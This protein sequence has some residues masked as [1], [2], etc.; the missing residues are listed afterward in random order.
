MKKIFLLILIVLAASSLFAEKRYVQSKFGYDEKDIKPVSISIYDEESNLVYAYDTRDVWYFFKQI[1]DKDTNTINTYEYENGKLIREETFS[2]NKY[3]KHL[4]KYNED[5][6]VAYESYYNLYKS[7]AYE[8]FYEVWY[9]YDDKGNEIRKKYSDGT[10]VEKEYNPDG[11]LL[12]M[13]ET[14]S[15]G[16]IEEAEEYNENGLLVKRIG[17][18]SETTCSYE[19]VGAF[20]YQFE[21]HR[22]N[23]GREYN[24]SYVYENGLL[25]EYADSRGNVTEYFYNQEGQ[26]VKEIDSDGEERIWKY[27]SEGR[28]IME[29]YY[30]SYYKFYDY[31][32]GGI[33]YSHV[34]GESE[35]I[36]VI[37]EQG[38][39]TYN[40]SCDYYDDGKSEMEMWTEY[41]Y[42]PN[43]NIRKIVVYNEVET[44][45]DSESAS[46][47][48]MEAMEKAIDK[49]FKD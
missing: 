16:K 9:E 19:E 28:V 25:K 22:Y 21:T 15:D 18:F 27:D 43:G 20:F 42:Y 12:F 29:P 34:P 31:L 33:T 17:S 46:K 44:S 30:G 35:S 26:K 24:Y 39:E 14:D 32:D 8:Y 3:K 2:D 45:D 13:K 1:N 10:V 4:L 40:Y 5:G 47:A 48:S 36:T 38:M 7:D 49:Y 6:N 37:N 11:V 23:D 41:E